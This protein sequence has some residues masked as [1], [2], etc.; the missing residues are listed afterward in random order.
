MS[1]ASIT[2]DCDQSGLGYHTDL[3]NALA[4]ISSMSSGPVAPTTNLVD[5]KLW[6]DNSDSDNVVNIRIGSTWHDILDFDGAHFYI[7]RIK[8]SSVSADS[9]ITGNAGTN[10]QVLQKQSAETGGQVWA[11]VAPTAAQVNALVYPVGSIYTSVGTLTDTSAKVA[12]LLGVGTWTAFGKGQVMVGFDSGQSEFDTILETG[13]AKT[14][15]LTTAQMPSHSH[16]VA[17]AEHDGSFDYGANFSANNFGSVSNGRSQQA[18]TSS[19]GS[20]SAHNNLQPY[21]TVYMWRRIT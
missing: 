17:G 14:H 9:M 15:T 10:N 7:T 20:G 5:G 1:Q 11:T 2:L 13:G 19:Q 16:K 21:V 4:N 18:D 3:N 12:A 6:L 8:D